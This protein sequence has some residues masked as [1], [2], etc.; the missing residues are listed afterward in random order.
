MLLRVALRVPFVQH[1]PLSSATIRP[2]P[3]SM[4]QPRAVAYASHQTYLDNSINDIRLFYL[5]SPNRRKLEHFIDAESRA[6]VRTPRESEYTLAHRLQTTGTLCPEVI[7]NGAWTLQ[8]Y[9]LL[10]LYNLCVV[11]EYAID[12]RRRSLITQVLT[13]L[14]VYKCQYHKLE[15]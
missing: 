4:R 6:A 8:Y 10:W 1:T 7:G 3:T 15:C 2:E 12:A 5:T 13:D 9:Q 14:E 11:W